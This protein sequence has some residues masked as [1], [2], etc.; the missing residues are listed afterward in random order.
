MLGNGSGDGQ[1]LFLTAGNIGT[2]LRDIAVEPIRLF[3]DELHCLGDL[4]RLLYLRIRR[5]RI[6]EPQVAGDRSGEQHALLRHKTDL[7][8][9]FFQRQITQF[10]AVQRN[11]ALCGI[12]Q[13]RDQIHQRGLAAAGAADDGCGLARFCGKT[14][15][16]QGILFGVRIA[17]MDMVE[18]QNAL[19]GV[20]VLRCL[21]F[22]DGSLCL[23]YLVNSSGSYRC[24]GQHDRH[25]GQHE[26]RHD[27]HHSI[28]DKRRHRTDL[29]G[30][31]VHTVC[32][33]PDD[34]NGQTVHNQHHHRHHKG[35]DTVDKQVGSGQIP[36]CL[37]E[38]LFLGLFPSE[39][40]N[41]RQTGQNLTGDQVHLIHQHL[42]Q[43]E[44]GHCNG[45]QH[46]DDPQ[47]YQNRQ[48]NDPAHACAGMYHL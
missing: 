40:T 41:D 43:L 17:E 13:T 45:H 15:I 18:C 12:V 46:A 30:A 24:T 29:H 20:Q 10:H 11:A 27:D 44:L 48:D 25:H 19:A 36:V 16:R 32:A 3:S 21:A 7:L 2:A 34:Q 9:Q 14:Q 5:I 38:T 1:T 42:H 28:G 6:A 47:N 22:L 39:C 26:E 4:C 37:V 8:P 23:Q 31:A 33:D 35:H